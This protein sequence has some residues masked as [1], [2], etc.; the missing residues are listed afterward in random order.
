VGEVWENP[1]LMAQ[2]LTVY[3]EIEKLEPKMLKV[4]VDPIA[5]KREI[6]FAKQ[7]I[8]SSQIL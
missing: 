3:Q 1:Y 5:V 4:L 2:E 8:A 6:S 7:L